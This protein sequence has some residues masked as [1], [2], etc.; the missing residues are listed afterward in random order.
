M[1]KKTHL[2]NVRG[3][4]HQWAFNVELDPKHL[5]ELRE[6]GLEVY[7]MGNSIP[8]WIVRCGLIRPWV[9]LQDC[10]Y[11]RNPFNQ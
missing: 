7:E 10:F 3:K 1:G 9:F 6:D 11:F 2:L 4:K 5:P 8:M